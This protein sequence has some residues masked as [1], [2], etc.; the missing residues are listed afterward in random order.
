MDNDKFSTLTVLVSESQCISVII[1]AITNNAIVLKI[2]YEFKIF[3][4]SFL[5][6]IPLSFPLFFATF[7]RGDFHKTFSNF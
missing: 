7:V 1:Y 4:L 5:V 3:N 6:I 2:I